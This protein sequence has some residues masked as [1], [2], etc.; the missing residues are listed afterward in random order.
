MVSGKLSGSLYFESRSAVGGILVVETLHRKVASAVRPEVAEKLWFCGLWAQFLYMFLSS[1]P[2]NHG[3]FHHCAELLLVISIGLCCVKALLLDDIS[4]RSRL[5]VFAVICLCT[6]SALIAKQRLFLGLIALVFSCRGIS[7]RRII[8]HYFLFT[9]SYIVLTLLLYFSGVLP[10]SISGVRF[11]GSVFTFYRFDL[12]FTHYNYAAMWFMLAMLYALLAYPRLHSASACAAFFALTWVVFAITSSRTVLLVALLAFCVLS[13]QYRHPRALERF[14]GL[15][16]ASV[17][18]IVLM[19]TMVFLLT[20]F[21]TSERS[22]FSL[23]NRILH[24]RPHHGYHVLKSDGLRLLGI[25]HEPSYFLDFLY[26][27]IAYRFGLVPMVLYIVLQIYAADKCIRAKQWDVWIV[28]IILVLYSLSEYSM[29][30][31]L[32]PL[33]YPAFANMDE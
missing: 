21:Y 9:V 2:W 22:I 17:C 33:L 25:S 4:I 6:L 24:N 10:T 19:I 27:Y 20:V 3:L 16:P 30:S 7:F 28:A 1:L 18:L 29:R 32:M 31:C 11:S 13:L 14:P 23:A 12:G 8:R 5:S 26:L 15:R